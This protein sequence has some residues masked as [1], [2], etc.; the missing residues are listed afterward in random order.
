MS[1]RKRAPSFSLQRD[2]GRDTRPRMEAQASMLP[3]AAHDGRDAIYTSQGDHYE[4]HTSPNSAI[5]EEQESSATAST[6]A[7][8]TTFAAGPSIPSLAEHTTTAG[9][10]RSGPPHICTVCGKHFFRPST[11]A[12]HMNIHTGATPYLCGFQG[13]SARFNARSNATRHRYLHGATFAQEQADIETGRARTGAIFVEPLVAPPSGVSVAVSD[14]SESGNEAGPSGVGQS[15][16]IS[17]DV[18]WMPVNQT[19]RGRM[20]F[21]AAKAST[22]RVAKRRQGGANSRSDS[23]GSGAGE[24]PC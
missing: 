12:T 16:Q 7:S 8:S 18:R 17:Q 5:P 15:R 11:L 21:T 22:T 13:C 10:P 24:G 2:S 19:T 1:S 6:S 4:A 9:R 14:A 20:S 3:Q 23:A